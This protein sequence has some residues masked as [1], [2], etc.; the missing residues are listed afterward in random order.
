MLY[1]PLLL[2]RPNRNILLAGIMGCC[3]I[4]LLYLLPRTVDGLLLGPEPEEVEESV[5]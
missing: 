1:A 4:V 3:A 5:S 2:R